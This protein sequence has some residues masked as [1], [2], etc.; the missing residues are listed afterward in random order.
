MKRTLKRELSFTPPTEANNLIKRARKS[1]VLLEAEEHSRVRF[2][3]DIVRHSKV[4]KDLLDC[5]HE[6]KTVNEWT[7]PDE[8]EFPVS[9]NR[10]FCTNLQII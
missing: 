6:G 2:E 7:Q 9:F 3:T 8:S 1:I 10:V 5:E 4:L